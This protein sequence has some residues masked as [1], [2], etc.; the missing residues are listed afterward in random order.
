[1]RRRRFTRWAV[2]GLGFLYIAAGIGETVRLVRS[3]DGGL[4][5]WFGTLVGGGLLVLLGELLHRTRAG[6]AATLICVGWLVTVPATIWTLV[7]PVLGL[8]VGI[9]AL[10]RYDDQTAAHGTPPGADPV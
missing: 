5:F 1:V 8:A 9:L 4:L 6:L 2:L 10:K 3:G 7:V